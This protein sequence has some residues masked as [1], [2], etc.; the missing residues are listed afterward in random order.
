[1]AS[2]NSDR[3][4]AEAI[5]TDGTLELYPERVRIR[6]KGFESL[7]TQGLRG[8]KDIALD[9]ISSVQFKSAGTLS[10]GYIKF[11]LVGRRAGKDDLFQAVKDENTVT[12][13]KSQQA[14]FEAIRRI[15]E[16]QI[17]PNK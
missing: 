1:M 5:G 8:E 15:I 3:P 2:T 17:K 14:S 16:G 7:F 4:N 10:S 9:S 11:A 13:K 12:F 6:R